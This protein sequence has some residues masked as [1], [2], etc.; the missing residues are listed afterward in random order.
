N[1]IQGQ[2]QDPSQPGPAESA[3]TAALRQNPGLRETL[4]TATYDRLKGALPKAT[5]KPHLQD[6][7]PEE[8]AQLA[9]LSYYIAE[10]DLGI[11][12]DQVF[13]YAALRE[14]KERSYLRAKLL[15]GTGHAPASHLFLKVNFGKPMKWISGATVTYCV[16]RRTFFGEA[17][18]ED[19]VQRMEDA[20]SAWM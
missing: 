7:K 2:G 3:F 18:Y 8:A 20:T 14:E 6:A 15:G 12:E 10:G 19:I 13:Y 5:I 9:E 1:D 4:K 11:D 17:E 16:Q